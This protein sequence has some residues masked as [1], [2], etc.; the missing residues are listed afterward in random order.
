MPYRAPL[1]CTDPGC[2]NTRPCPDHPGASPWARRMPPG[3]AAT[4]R[5]ILARD[6]GRCVQCGTPATE[7]HHTQP[8]REDDGS[9]VSLCSGCHRAI[10][11]QR[12]A[13]ARG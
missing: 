11:A 2:P 8:G 4:R 5:R 13:A 3:W 10:T 7:V 6:G 12:A 1:P 9:L